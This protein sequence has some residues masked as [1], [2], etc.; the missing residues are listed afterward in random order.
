MN[1]ADTRDDALFHANLGKWQSSYRQIHEICNKHTHT[2]ARTHENVLAEDKKKRESEW[3][4]E[5]K[6]AIGGKIPEMR[7]NGMYRQS[8]CVSNCNERKR[9]REIGRHK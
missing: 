7:T 8:R 1:A 2:R 4:N 6:I 9:M 3:R 5:Q